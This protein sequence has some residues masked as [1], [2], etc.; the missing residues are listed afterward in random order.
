MDLW[1]KIFTIWYS[2]D[3]ERSNQSY[4][5]SLLCLINTQGFT[6][7]NKSKIKYPINNSA[8]L[9]VPHSDDLPIPVFSSLPQDELL[10]Q[11]CHSVNKICETTN[12][13]LSETNE[14]QEFLAT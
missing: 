4:N 9:P 2:N 10:S 6:A 1:K 13:D 8:V 5:Q 11:A 7:K 14:Y 12:R 3:M